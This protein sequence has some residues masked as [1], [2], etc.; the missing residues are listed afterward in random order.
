MKRVELT[1]NELGRI[2]EIY[3]AARRS[4]TGEPGATT[5]IRIRGTRSISASNEP[6]IIV[7][8]VIDGIRIAIIN[9]TDLDKQLDTEYIESKIKNVVYLSAKSGD[10]RAEL[11]KAVE[12]IAGMD[13]FNPSEG[14]LSN[15]RQRQAVLNSLNS[16][17]D[18]KNALEI[19]LTYDAITVSI[20]EA[21]TS[22]LELTGERTSD[23]VVDRVFHNFCVGK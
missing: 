17:K 19:G 4:T 23:E 2:Q 14:V 21:I 22:L 15:E 9:K 3:A 11:V 7:D 13:N 18:A 6:L 5:S 20:E 1:F 12:D 8:G 16:V 10:G